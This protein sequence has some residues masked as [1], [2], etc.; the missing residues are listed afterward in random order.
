M[1]KRWPQGPWLAEWGVAH[2]RTTGI[3]PLYV[4]SVAPISPLSA[5]PTM[6]PSRR[7]VGKV[8][9][10]LYSRRG[11]CDVFFEQQRD[12]SGDPHIFFA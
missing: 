9:G 7:P 6:P 3:V 1:P 5:T 4:G 12:S 10:D 8:G 2:V 11:S